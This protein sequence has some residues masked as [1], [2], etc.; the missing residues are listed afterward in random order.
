MSTQMEV[1]GALKE[2]C[3]VYATTQKFAELSLC[4]W[5]RAQPHV[6][7]CLCVSILSTEHNVYRQTQFCAVESIV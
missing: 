4:F 7:I 2:S 6:Q 3:Q 1:C 5:Y